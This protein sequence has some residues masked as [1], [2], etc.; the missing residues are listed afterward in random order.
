MG[1][2]D[3]D[4]HVELD[5]DASDEFIAFSL[6]TFSTIGA[7]GAGSGGGGGGE[8]ASPNILLIPYWINGL[9][10][11]VVVLVSKLDESFDDWSNGSSWSRYGLFL[12]GRRV[13][14]VGELAFKGSGGGSGGGGGRIDRLE[15]FTNACSARSGWLELAAG[16]V[17]VLLDD[18]DDDE[19][20]DELDD[21][22]IDDALDDG[23]KTLFIESDVVLSLLWDDEDD[24]DDD[25]EEEEEEDDDEDEWWVWW[26]PDVTLLWKSSRCSL[27]CLES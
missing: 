8:A 2:L 25:D 18:D 12:A 21:G 4:E 15:L 23:L 10:G 1:E 27:R 17:G 19:L 5:E 26:W 11:V 7:A 3:G 24:E 14:G 20:D 22:D 16:G 13:D 9:L 6:L